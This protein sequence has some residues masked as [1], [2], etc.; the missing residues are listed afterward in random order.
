MSWVIPVLTAWALAVAV[1]DARFRRLPNALTLGTALLAV[2]YLAGFGRGPLDTAPA[3]NLLAA[4]LFLLFLLPA[5]ARHW[6]GGGD[7]KLGVAFG[8]L[9]G[10]K[11]AL[12]TLGAGGLLVAALGWR[13]QRARKPGD[14]PRVVP[15]G[16]AHGLAF[17]AAVVVMEHMPGGIY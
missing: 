4:A 1:L 12:V 2:T 15:W 17:A 13:A 16:T 7:V 11:A 10:L 9:G 8:L 3:S 6:V 14:P 5:Y